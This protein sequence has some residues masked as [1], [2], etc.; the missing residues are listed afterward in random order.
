MTS[1]SYLELS[2]TPDPLF[3]SPA[4]LQI[5]SATERNDYKKKPGSSDTARQRDEIIT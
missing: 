1:H 4:V 5:P 3:A 2:S